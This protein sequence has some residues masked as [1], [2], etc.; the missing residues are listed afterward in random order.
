MVDPA[1]DTPRRWE[2]LLAA[3][4]ALGC[5]LFGLALL[6][7]QTLDAYDQPLY[8]GIASDLQQTG[9]YTNGRWGE[10]AKPGAY[11]APLYPALVAGVAMLDGR[12]ARAAACVRVAEWAAIPSCP[13]S[14]GLLVPL[15]VV[16]LAGTLLLVWRSTLAIGGRG[17]PPGWRCWRPG[18]APRN[19]Q[20][21]PARR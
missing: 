10:A 2:W 15:Q 18:S 11:T 13:G 1:F 19:T 12:L 20:S 16:L 8:L 9:T 6:R 7:P 4:V 17:R 21:T 5:V 14:L 3:A